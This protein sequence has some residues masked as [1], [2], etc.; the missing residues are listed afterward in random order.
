MAYAGLA[1]AYI[2]SPDYIPRE[3]Y[4]KAKAAALKALELDDAIAEAH[5]SLGWILIGYEHDFQGGEKEYRKAF[6][7]NPNYATAHQWYGLYLAAT[8]RPDEALREIHLAQEI[9]PLSLIMYMGAAF[10]LYMAGRYD[11]A[12]EECRKAMDLDP[13]FGLA[14]YPLVFIHDARGEYDKAIEGWA[15]IFAYEQED[16]KAQEILKTYADS[17]YKAAMMLV[18]DSLRHPKEPGGSHMQNAAMVAATIG[19]NDIAMELLE[20]S[21]ERLEPELFW[22]HRMPAFESLRSDPRFQKF[23]EGIGA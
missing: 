5:T 9:D 4:P 2:M 18:L 20:K 23:L 10:M 11:E 17:G 7:L 14:H 6:E 22:V 16:K 13:N 19:E 15:A 1:D 12:E 21:A 3:A 8:G